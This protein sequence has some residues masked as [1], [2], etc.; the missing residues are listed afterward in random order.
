MATGRLRLKRAFTLLEILVALVIL[1]T[2]I[3]T[4]VGLFSASLVSSV[5]AENTDIAMNLA[6]ARMEEIRN[7]DF[8]TGIVNEARAAVSGFAGFE[9]E[10]VVATPETD[11]KQVTVNVFWSYK[12]SEI[13]VPLVTYI[14]K[15]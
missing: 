15:N 4:I 3:I 6:Q 11:L 7:L 13:T 12:S 1:T 8:D 9:R 2:G 14:S 10:V 5:D